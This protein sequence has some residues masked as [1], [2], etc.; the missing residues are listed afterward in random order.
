MKKL[1]NKPEFLRY[2]V[3]ADVIM[4]NSQGNNVNIDDLLNGEINPFSA[5]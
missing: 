5:E 2:E 1:Y 4:N 3:F